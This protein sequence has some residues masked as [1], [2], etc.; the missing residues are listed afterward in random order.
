HSDLPA[1]LGETGRL[2]GRHLLVSRLNEPRP[3]VG[4]AEGG[5]ETVDP[6]ARISEDLLD[7]P[8]TETSQ[9]VIAHLQRHE[10]SWFWWMARRRERPTRSAPVQPRRAAG[11][12]NGG[13]K[14]VTG[15][16]EPVEVVWHERIRWPRTR[17]PAAGRPDEPGRSAEPGRA[18]GGPGRPGRSGGAG[19]P[20]ESGEPCRPHG[21]EGAGGP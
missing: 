4:A 18:D 8:F 7:T 16:G 3:I 19:Q 21:A 10:S 9:Y 1:E 13:G 2:E 14:R 17:S 5:H 15:A 12:V 11:Y 6:V 20:D